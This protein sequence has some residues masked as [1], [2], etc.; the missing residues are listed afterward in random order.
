MN[1]GY[2][3]GDGSWKFSRTNN[4]YKSTASGKLQTCFTL[5]LITKC[6][7][8]GD[9]SRR[10]HGKKVAYRGPIIEMTAAFWTA[11]V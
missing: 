8:Q 11:T 4:S 3:L 2:I 6:Q 5:Q 9:D 7:R 1:R 10:S